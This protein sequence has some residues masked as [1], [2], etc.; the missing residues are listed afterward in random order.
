MAHRGDS[1]LAATIGPLPSVKGSAITS[2]VRYVRDR[3]GESALRRLKVELSDGHRVALEG[4]VLPHAWVPYDLFIALNTKIDTLFGKGDLGL[5]REMGRYS[6]EVN[7][8]TLYRIFYK[9][10]TPMFIFSK[11]ARLW[12]VHY[13]SGS[14]T[15]VQE[16]PERVRLRIEGFAEPHRAHCL[17]VLGWAEQSIEISG[18]VVTDGREDKCR[19]KGDGACELLLEWKP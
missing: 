5:C 14:L 8:P 6:A 4:K 13:D 18:A 10:G 9:L 1:P 19:T 12:Q 15:P 7:L 2:R 11:A 3:F 17:S 16:T